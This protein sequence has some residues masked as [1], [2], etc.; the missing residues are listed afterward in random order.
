MRQKPVSARA[1]S[2][3]TGVPQSTVSHLLSGRSSQKPEHL[4]ALARYFGVS[5]EY[6][7]FGE[8]QQA[9]QLES[10]LTEE[11]FT[12]WLKVRVERV[13]PTKKR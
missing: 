8:D 5:L 13:V 12:G 7:I 3:A 6:L 1:L 10:I 9:N 11:V 2:K 4:L